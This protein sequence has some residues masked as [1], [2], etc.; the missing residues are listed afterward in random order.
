M[1]RE[2]VIGEGA[3][4]NHGAGDPACLQGHPGKQKAEGEEHARND[5]MNGKNGAARGHP[6]RKREACH[7]QPGNCRGKHGGD[8]AGDREHDGRAFHDD[9]HP[10][11]G[12]A[13]EKTGPPGPKAVGGF[14]RWTRRPQSCQARGYSI[15]K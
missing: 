2:G 7:D 10:R 14:W 6:V 9:L 13:A 15:S 11:Q 5:Q 4:T 8:P 12:H 1:R 3:D